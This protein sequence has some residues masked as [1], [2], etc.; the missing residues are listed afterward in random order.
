MRFGFLRNINPLLSKNVTEVVVKVKIN[1][2]GTGQIFIFFQTIN[3]F[4]NKQMQVA[5][6]VDQ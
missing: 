1:Y 2:L 5:T 3:F 6:S 4:S